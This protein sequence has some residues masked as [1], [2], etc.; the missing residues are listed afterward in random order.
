MKFCMVI[1]CAGPWAGEIGKLAGIGIDEDVLKVPIPVEPRY[2]CTH[3]E[4][5]YVSFL[6]VRIPDR[7]HQQLIIMFLLNIHSKHLNVVFSSM[8]S[9]LNKLTVTINVLQKTVRVYCTLSRWT[10]IGHA[11][12]TGQVRSIHQKRRLRGILH[13]WNV[14]RSS[15]QNYILYWEL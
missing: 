6:S 8:S 4:Q 14:S 5:Q 10:W 3:I 9:Y 15:M 12:H 2:Q 7:C 13:L 1:N 11:C